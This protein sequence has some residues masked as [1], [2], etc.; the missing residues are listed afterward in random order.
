VDNERYNDVW[1]LD[2]R[3]AKNIKIAGS[4]SL[5]IN[6]DVFNALNNNV[7]LVSQRT[8]NSAVFGRVDEILSPRILRIGATFRF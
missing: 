8:L 7:G 4:S 1:N 3:L 2:F 5:N 6:L